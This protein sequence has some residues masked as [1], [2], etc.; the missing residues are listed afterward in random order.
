MF[1]K[2]I[3]APIGDENLKLDNV[4]KLHIHIKK[5]KAP[6]GDENFIIF[7]SLNIKSQYY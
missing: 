4:L 7:F 2:K 6:I 1:I 3:K 5:I